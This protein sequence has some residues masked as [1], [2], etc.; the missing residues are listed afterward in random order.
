MST[1]HLAA[2]SVAPPLKPEKIRLYSMRFYPYAQRIHLVLYAKMIPY[3]VVYV[4]LMS[5]PE[6]LL[7]KSPYGKVPRVEMNGGETLYESLIIADYLDKVYPQNMLNIHK[8]VLLEHL[9]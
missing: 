9:I 1:K 7:E 4:N 6:W 3:D 8:V 2:G 5:K